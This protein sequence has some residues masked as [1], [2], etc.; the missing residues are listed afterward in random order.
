MSLECIQSNWGESFCWKDEGGCCDQDMT[1]GF[2]KI[3]TCY[4]PWYEIHK[5]HMAGGQIIFSYN[6]ISV[7]IEHLLR[8]HNESVYVV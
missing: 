5:S 8:V 2:T 4:V 3:S 6:V 7:N 1:C